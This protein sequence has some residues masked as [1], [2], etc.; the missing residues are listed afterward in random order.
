MLAQGGYYFASQ[1]AAEK[2]AVENTAASLKGEEKIRLM[3]QA[4][5]RVQTY[6]QDETRRENV[7]SDWCQIIIE[8]V[9]EKLVSE[10]G[11][12]EMAELTEQ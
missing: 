5:E 3:R 8:S 1:M 11:A 10:Y 6:P 12:F 9:F 4:K 7:E 2:Q